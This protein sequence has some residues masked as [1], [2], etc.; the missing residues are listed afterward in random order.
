MGGE[1]VLTPI[2]IASRREVTAMYNVLMD[3]Y[4]VRFR[5]P[6]WQSAPDNPEAVIDDWTKMEQLRFMPV[7]L[8]IPAIEPARVAVERSLGR[9]D[10]VIIGLSL[11]L[12]RRQ[13]A[14]FEE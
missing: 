13:V 7:T 1:A 6:L 12:Y 8:L 4:S 11:E 14:F 5:T 3:G 2:S 10:G 9:R